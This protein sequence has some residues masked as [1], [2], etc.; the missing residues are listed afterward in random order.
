MP[1]ADNMPQ[2]FVFLLVEGLSMMSLASAIEPLRS[3]NRLLG[4][5]AYRWLL[6][7]VD[8]S[9]VNASNGIALST[10]SAAAAIDGADILFVRCGLRVRPQHERRY[11][12][13]LRRAARQG[14]ALGRC[15]PAPIC[16]H[17][18]AC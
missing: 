5:D 18:Q 15:Q 17:G 2:T 10:E 13:I 7:S 4:Q 14:I 8:G 12:G 16:W 11:F 9:P 1:R 6:A 3:L